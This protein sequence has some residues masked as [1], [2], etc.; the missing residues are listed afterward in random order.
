VL[1]YER[2][3]W[4]DVTALAKGLRIAEDR[5]PELAAASLGWAAETLPT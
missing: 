1:A 2:A 3:A 4:S 5:L